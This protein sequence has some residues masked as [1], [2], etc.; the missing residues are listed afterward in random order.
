[1]DE[2]KL[3]NGFSLH[4]GLLRLSSHSGKVKKYD[5]INIESMPGSDWS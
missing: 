5:M 3:A 2:L 4:E 1:M